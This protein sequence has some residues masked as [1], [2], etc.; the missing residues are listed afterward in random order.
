MTA[1]VTSG[2]YTTSPD[3]T[4]D[5]VDDVAVD[6]VLNGRKLDRVLHHAERIALARRVLA[7]G[8][9]SGELAKLLSCS[10][11]VARELVDAARI[12]G[13]RR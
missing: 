11:P 3:L 2:L 1:G 9:G 8:G 7:R 10:A 12:P 13:H 4:P 6:R 5:W